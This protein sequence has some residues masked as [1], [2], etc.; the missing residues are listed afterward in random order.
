M[1]A[2]SPGGEDLSN[3]GTY[4]KSQAEAASKYTKQEGV[5][6]QL[7]FVVPSNTLEAI[8]QTVFR[9]VE[10]N[11]YV[12]PVEAL[13]PVILSMVSRKSAPRTGAIFL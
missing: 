2:K 11:V 12:I 1:D 3:F 7:F 5:F 6:N 8:P 10:Y 4:L 13:E 9:F